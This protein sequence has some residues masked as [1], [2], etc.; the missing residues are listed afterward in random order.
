MSGSSERSIP[1]L[2][3][4]IAGNIQQI[5]TAEIRLVN[6]ESRHQVNR[7]ARSVALLLVGGAIWMLALACVLFAAIDLLAL[8][9]APWVAALVVAAAAGATGAMLIQAGLRLWRRVTPAQ[10]QTS[11]IG[12][13]IQWARPPAS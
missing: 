11:A 10:P 1:T 3:K 9:V 7:A 12:E 2:L 6:V 5:V 4:D 13:T 8:V